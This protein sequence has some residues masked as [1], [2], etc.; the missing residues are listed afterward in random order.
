MGHRRE[1]PASTSRFGKSIPPKEIIMKKITALFL[2][3][4][5]VTLGFL[6]S[7]ESATSTTSAAVK[8]ESSQVYQGAL[9][10]VPGTAWPQFTFALT[11]IG[12]SPLVSASLTYAVDATAIAASILGGTWQANNNGTYKATNESISAA[13]V[14]YTS[15]YTPDANETK[16][17][18]LQ[19]WSS[20]S[21]LTAF[22][23]AHVYVK[24]AVLTYADS[25]VETITFPDST[26][27][28]IHSVLVS[29]TTSTATDPNFVDR[30]WTWTGDSSL[31]VTSGATTVSF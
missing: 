28:T 31:T 16:A 23:D 15:S 4:G 18:Q 14:W 10:L 9:S 29:G 17:L 25:S 27:S 20:A 2:A 5:L 19:F 11:P 30:I 21:A 26:L 13:K 12:T 3:A 1:D 8:T 24:T 6:A 22:T 7:C